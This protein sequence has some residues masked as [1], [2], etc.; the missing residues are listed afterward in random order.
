[1]AVDVKR[2]LR[3]KPGTFTAWFLPLVVM[4]ENNIELIDVL[5]LFGIDKLSEAIER[6][7]GSRIIFPT[8]ATV[9]ALVRDAYLLARLDSLIG[10]PSG[11]NKARLEEEFGAPIELLLFRARAVKGALRRAARV[12]E[13]PG[14][15]AASRWLEEVQKTNGE[16][17]LIV[18]EANNKN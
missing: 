12:Q 4:A 13:M 17:A 7:G 2:V 10:K 18:Q 11:P 16:I 9:D 3:E 5:E 14:A 8:W 1:V 15:E 6:L